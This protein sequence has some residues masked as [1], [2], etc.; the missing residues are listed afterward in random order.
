MTTSTIRV[1]LERLIELEDTASANGADPDTT[2]WDEAVATGRAVLKAEPEG[3]GPSLADVDELC[4]EFGFHPDDDQGEGLEILSDMI[5]AAIARWGAPVVKPA[6]PPAPEPGEVKDVID[7]LHRVANALSDEDLVGSA[8]TCRR[9]A[10]L[11]Q[12]QAAELAALRGAPVSE[13]LPE[14]NTKVLAHYCNKLGKGRTICAIWVPAKTRVSDS[15]I[16]EDLQFEYDY[17]TDQF[18]WPQ[19]WYEAI[20][21]WEEFG[22][23]KVYEGEVTYWEP[24]P[25]WPANALPLPAP[26][27]GEGEA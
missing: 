19:G 20:E 4:A 13:R 16:D 26:Q 10:T 18:Y 12:H 1:A 5:T 6:T 14:P 8:H 11:F 7:D 24:L 15:D 21:N 25:K 9:A 2:A 23:L 27:A 3:E 22:Y 17:E